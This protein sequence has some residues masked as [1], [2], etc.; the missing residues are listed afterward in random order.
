MTLGALVE[1]PDVFFDQWERAALLGRGLPG[2]D[3]V[4]SLEKIERLLVDQGLRLPFL[5]MV[6]QGRGVPT[7]YFTSD[8]GQG[9]GSVT[10]LASY[11]KVCDLIAT[12]NTLV[13]QGVRHYLP[14]VEAFCASVEAELGHQIGANIYLSPPHAQGAG[15]HYDFHS[16]F[17]KQLSGSKTWR[18]RE[19][20]EIWPRSPF[21]GLD[22]I[23]ETPVLG[24]TDLH[25]GDCLYLPRGTIH[26]GWTTDEHSMHL[27][28]SLGDPHTLLDLMLDALR[29]S[30]IEEAAV[31]QIAPLRPDLHMV[32]FESLL[33][34]VQVILREKLMHLDLESLAR[35][36]AQPLQ[37]RPSTPPVSLR[38]LLM[39]PGVK[40]GQ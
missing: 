7:S 39:N 5:K 29:A 26:D 36:A 24:E 14:T 40:C 25:A 38:D 21:L 28:I 34:D 18:F 8:I 15:S 16:V 35:A 3:H 27:T 22:Q 19:P 13:L 1:S 9:R 23:P 31:R 12:G 17:I 37:E 2:L 30:A 33:S 6:K 32:E 10:G 4:V 20:P 11:G